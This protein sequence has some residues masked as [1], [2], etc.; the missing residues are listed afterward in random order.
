[1]E[2]I[3]FGSQDMKD[4]A[5]IIT[6][7]PFPDI[8]DISQRMGIIQGVNW[9]IGNLCLDYLRKLPEK[10]KISYNKTT[11]ALEKVFENNEEIGKRDFYFNYTEELRNGSYLSQ[12]ILDIFENLGLEIACQKNPGLVALTASLTYLNILES[13][14]L[15]IHNR[16]DLDTK[17]TA[18][19][20]QSPKKPFPSEIFS[21]KQDYDWM[22]IT[23]RN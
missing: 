9:S 7:P 1:M 10:I 3:S 13:R 15:P 23:D 11:N 18:Y 6:S 21:K 2:D 20:I 5:S 8:I 19:I 12:D 17:G 22:D 16:K 4:Y 14:I